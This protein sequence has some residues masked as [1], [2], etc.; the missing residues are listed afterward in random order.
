MTCPC[1]KLE[2][3]I[4]IMEADDIHDAAKLARADVCRMCPDRPE[5]KQLR[6]GGER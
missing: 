3:R 4:A 5:P 1:E 6:L 2:E